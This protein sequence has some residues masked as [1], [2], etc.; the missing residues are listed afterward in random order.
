[1]DPLLKQV[2]SVLVTTSGYWDSLCQCVSP[3]LLKQ[4]PAEGEWSALECLQHLIDTEQVFQTR[5]KAFLAGENFPGFDPDADGSPAGV[6]LN[7]I[8]LAEEFTRLRQSGIDL[9]DTVTP[10][11]YDRTAIHGELGQVTLKQLLN[12]WAGHDLNHTVQA[13][14]AM[15]QPFITAC[16]PW[17]RYF[18]D[19]VVG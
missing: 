3:E 4:S 7:Q 10:D 1:M 15:M 17:Q 8:E 11:D 9:L 13:Q 2:R 5:I 19:H 6:E 12:E 14:R 16:G 18:T